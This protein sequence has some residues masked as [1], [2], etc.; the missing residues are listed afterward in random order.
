MISALPF[1]LKLPLAKSFSCCVFPLCKFTPCYCLPVD[2]IPALNNFFMVFFCVCAN[3]QP[4]LH[5]TVRFS[6]LEKSVKAFGVS[7]TGYFRL[8]RTRYRKFKKT[9]T[10]LKKAY[11]S[12]WC[13]RPRLA[14]AWAETWMGLSWLGNCLS[15][16]LGTGLHSP[17]GVS[18]APRRL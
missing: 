12:I 17:R 6:T 16:S 18:G 13:S 5:S 2:I 7:V 11:P 10:N 3:S 15:L 4:A 8:P 14:T 1:A 9:H